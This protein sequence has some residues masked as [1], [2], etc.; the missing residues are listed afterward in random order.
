MAGGLEGPAPFGEYDGRSYGAVIRLCRGL[1]CA[2][3]MD[4]NEPE[5]MG[6]FYRLMPQRIR[7]GLRP[8]RDAARP[9]VCI[10]CGE[11]LGSYAVLSYSTGHVGPGPIGR[12]KSNPALKLDVSGER[13][14]VRLRCPGCRRNEAV[15][16]ERYDPSPHPIRI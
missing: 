16:L 7:R 14:R 2:H 1:C 13:I 9:H 4:V 12:G 3:A 11:P 10:A 15:P 5:I 6:E 8:T